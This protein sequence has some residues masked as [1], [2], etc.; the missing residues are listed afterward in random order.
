M[1]RKK[2]PKLHL[3]HKWTLKELLAAQDNT[4]TPGP[5]VHAM[6]EEKV[7]TAFCRA[8]Y[9][10]GGISHKFTSPGEV[11]LEDRIAILPGGRVWF[12]ELKRPGKG[13]RKNQQVMHER[14]AALGANV[15]VLNTIEKVINW[16]NDRSRE[17]G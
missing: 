11:A 9:E 6:L 16:K 3:G 4:P 17:H 13:A 7:E 2:T 10:L 8:V 15:A 14:H 5:V 1:A 12:V